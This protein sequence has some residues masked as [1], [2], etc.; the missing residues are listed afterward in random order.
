MP[1]LRPI[2][3]ASWAVYIILPAKF[4]GI[5]DNAPDAETAVEHAIEKYQVPPNECS[6]LI[7]VP[8]QKRNTSGSRAAPALAKRLGQARR[9]RRRLVSQ[10]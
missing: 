5:I 2:R 6:R 4:V 1:K 3:H 9:S 10:M 7:A 8:S